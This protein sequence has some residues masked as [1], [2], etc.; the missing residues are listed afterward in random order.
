MRVM[1]LLDTFEN[2]Y[3]GTESQLIKQLKRLPDY[4]VQA[5]MTVLRSSD[6]LDSV[7]DFVCP[8]Q[9]LKIYSIARPASV[10]KMWQ[11]ARQTKARGF[12]I[13]HIYFNDASILAPMILKAAGLKVIITRLDMGYWLTP[14]NQRILQFNQRFLDAAITNGQAVKQL[15]ADKE[16]VPLDK[17]HVIYNGYESQQ[18]ETAAVVPQFDA[19]TFVVGHVAN[20]RPIKRQDDLIR[21]FH[22]LHQAVPDSHLIIV[23]G[24]DRQDLEALVDALD[25]RAVV[26]FAGQQNPVE[27]WINLFDVAVLCSES[28]GFSNSLVEYLKQGKPSICTAVGGNP[29]IVQDGK[30][31]YLISVGDV[32]AMAG[33]L[34]QLQSDAR[35]Y[36]QMSQTARDTVADKFTMQRMM[37]GY[38]DVYQALYPV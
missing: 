19:S 11:F 22:Q 25:I 34:L 16:H 6:Y 20:I 24:G 30:N 7:D 17:I 4:S 27:P 12:E 29:E 36:A 8:V 35:L 21:A 1:Y 28:E 15:T 32:D 2:P 37:Q 23:G 10:Q 9:N 13:V 31:G 5:E 18:A 38:V 26:T 3:A 33:H 14:V